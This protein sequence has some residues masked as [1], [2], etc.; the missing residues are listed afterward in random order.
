M[1]LQSSLL[2]EREELTDLWR[3]WGYCWGRAPVPLFFF[4]TF[5]STVRGLPTLHPF[6]NSDWHARVQAGKK[7]GGQCWFSTWG[8]KVRAPQSGQA[9]SHS[10]KPTRKNTQRKWKLDEEEAHTFCYGQIMTNYSSFCDKITSLNDRGEAV[11]V[12]LSW[13]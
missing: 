11:A 8:Q 6:R 7:Q 3:T 5:G 1:S 12:T 2:S 10:W 13:L 4:Q 9:V